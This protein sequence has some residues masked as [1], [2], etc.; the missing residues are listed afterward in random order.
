MTVSESSIRGEPV[1]PNFQECDYAIGFDRME[2]GDRYFRLPLA[3]MKLNRDLVDSIRKRDRV[4]AEDIRGKR[5]CNFI[6]SNSSSGR[7]ARLRSEFCRQLMEYKRVDCPGM[8]LHNMD[9][10]EISSRYASDCD[11]SKIGFLRKYKFTIAFE[12]KLLPGYSTEKLT[13]PFIAGSIPIY[14]GDPGITDIFNPAAFIN[15]GDYDNDFHKII[16]RVIEIDNDEEQALAMLNADPFWPGY[17]CDWEERLADF[18]ADM[19]RKGNAPFDKESSEET[20]EEPSSELVINRAFCRDAVLERIS[21]YGKIYVY[22]DG[23][24]ARKIA[25][26]LERAGIR[27]D[28]FCISQAKEERSFNN[29][30]L[31]A[32][33]DIREEDKNSVLFL[34]AVREAAISCVAEMLKADGYDNLL[35]C[36]AA[37]LRMVGE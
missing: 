24:Y 29:A 14:C 25:S 3:E 28:A 26:V 17:S 23:K 27:I 18:L 20:A 32:Y 2:Y 4:S 33:G 12:N 15:G 36:T 31:L 13:D 22:G 7:G 11:S 34:I 19:I 35:E 16:R 6:Y 10:G 21:K 8:V 30:P 9:S 1:S 5:F 37:F